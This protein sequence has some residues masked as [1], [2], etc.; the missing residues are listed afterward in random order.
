MLLKPSLSPVYCKSTLQGKVAGTSGHC[1]RT[2]G[3][4]GAVT[5]THSTAARAETEVLPCPQH[6]TLPRPKGQ[7]GPFKFPN[8]LGWQ[9]WV[10]ETAVESREPRK[11]DS[12]PEIDPQQMCSSEDSGPSEQ[13]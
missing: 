7:G 2:E 3:I 11:A 1:H 13:H 12:V 5:N 9:L 6:H 10:G 8:V 4:Q